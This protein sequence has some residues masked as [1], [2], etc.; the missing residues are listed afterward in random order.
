MADVFVDL[1]YRGLALGS[2]VRLGD[3]S[4]ARGYLE[5]PAPMP[6]GTLISLVTGDQAVGVL[7][8]KVL[9]VVE[10]TAG[11]ERPPGMVVRPTLDG[12]AARAWWGGLGGD[13]MSSQAGAAATTKAPEPATPATIPPRSAAEP[14]TPAAAPPTTAPASVEAPSAPP[15]AASPA[16]AAPSAQ[17]PSPSAA[18]APGPVPDAPSVPDA[19]ASSS[20]LERGGVVSAVLDDQPTMP[21]EVGLADAPA[22]EE[23]EAAEASGGDA[24][25]AEPGA[26]DSAELALAEGEELPEP[27]SVAESAPR[28]RKRRRNRR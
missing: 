2:R 15:A 21:T 9:E 25:A 14:A 1:L 16:P 11:S 7:P 27:P 23:P 5:V 18:A 10:Q 17:S 28:G 26:G 8:A 24:E 19:A 13:S 12:E 22:S 3:V 20:A 6:V 4:G